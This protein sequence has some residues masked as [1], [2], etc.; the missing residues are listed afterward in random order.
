MAP[1]PPPLHARDSPGHPP[2]DENWT[3]AYV[4]IVLVPVAFIIIAVISILFGRWKRKRR[5]GGGGDA[6]RADGQQPGDVEMDRLRRHHERTWFP[7]REAIDE[8]ETEAKDE[9]EARGAA[10]DTE[11]PRTTARAGI[12]A[13][14]SSSTPPTRTL[15]P[16]AR[17]EWNVNARLAKKLSDKLQAGGGGGRSGGDGGRARETDVADM[18]ADESVSHVSDAPSSVITQWPELLKPEP[19]PKPEPAPR[20]RR[21]SPGPFCHGYGARRDSGDRDGDIEMAR[22]QTEGMVDV[23]LGDGPQERESLDVEKERAVWRERLRT[24]T[25]DDDLPPPGHP[26]AQGNRRRASRR[27]LA[28]FFRPLV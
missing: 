2:T 10:A 25:R 4:V 28:K 18:D 22:I 8:T 6:A 24:L 19:E 21:P 11:T 13:S 26:P 20:V 3:T 7:W 5:A 15:T 27:G 1:T 9:G 12:V 16:V 17:P 23:D 14:P